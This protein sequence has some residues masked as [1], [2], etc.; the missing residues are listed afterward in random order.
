MLSMAPLPMAI[1]GAGVSV[2]GGIDFSDVFVERRD[3][4]IPVPLK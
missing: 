2:R 3:E 4:V 1:T